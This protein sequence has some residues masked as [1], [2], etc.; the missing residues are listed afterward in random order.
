MLKVAI[1]GCGAIART[2]HAPEFSANPHVTVAGFY[3]PTHSRAVEFAE[4]FGGKAFSSYD[5]LICEPG[6]DAVCV[7][8][9]NVAHADMAIRAL[10]RGLHVLCEKPM[11]A[12]L[13]DAELMVRAAEKSGKSLFIAQNQRL[14]RAHV[15]AKELLSRGEIGRVISFT[16]TFVH[17]GPESWSVEGADTW[18]MK[19]DAAAFGSMA[20][21]GVHKLDLCIWLLGGMV[22]E[23]FCEAA[24]L[25]KKLP[26]GAAIDVDDNAVAILRMESGALGTMITGWT[27]YGPERNSVVI[28]G[29]EGVMEIYCSPRHPL[30][31]LYKNG[32]SAVFMVGAMQTNDNQTS[33]GI[34]DLFVE[35][36]LGGA[37][38][39]ISGQDALSAMRVIDALSRSSESGAWEKVRG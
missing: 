32:E 19:R 12:K 28:Y 5:E 27:N 14:A 6:L 9:A 11:A 22:A 10:G 3:N 16:T 17:R 21:L 4:R 15:K 2:R 39:A 1:A 36:I 38:P 8:T 29:T 7:C 20:D 34:A 24:V 37:P 25:E 33:S 23:A 18:F 30:R 26:G 35:G 31:I 13:I